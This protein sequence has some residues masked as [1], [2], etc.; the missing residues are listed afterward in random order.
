MGGWLQTLVSIVKEEEPY[1]LTV[2]LDAAPGNRAVFS[3]DGV[4]VWVR[5]EATAPF[6][7]SYGAADDGEAVN[8]ECTTETLRRI[9]A[10]QETLDRAIASGKILVQAPLDNLLAMHRLVMSILADSP[11]SRRLHL[12][13]LEFDRMWHPATPTPSIEAGVPLAAQHGRFGVFLDYIPES[14]LKAGG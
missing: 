14:V 7:V 4:G 8:F 13:W 1:T 5:M 6:N 9:L 10:G 12:L 3:I 2:L 11:L